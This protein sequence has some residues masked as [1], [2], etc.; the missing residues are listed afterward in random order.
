M[1][2]FLLSLAAHLVFVFTW[3]GA[4]KRE[5]P[6]DPIPVAFL[7]SP[8]PNDARPIP[9]TERPRT[10]V[11]KT[12]AQLAKKSSPLLEETAKEPFKLLETEK[13]EE[14]RAYERIERRER[15]EIVRR[16]LPTWK[17]ILPPV[18]WSQQDAE[19]RNE[20]GAVPLN[21]RQPKYLSYF[22]SIQRAIEVVWDYPEPALRHGLQG[23]LVLEF[24]I[25]RNGALGETRL[26]RSSG[27]SILDEEAIRAVQTASPFHPIPPW[28]GTDRLEISA[29]FEY[30]DNRL[31]YGFMP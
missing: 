26:V 27:F 24:T 25:L 15:Q 30:H 7:P 1:P 28:I 9:K 23:R 14:R 13:R 8:K 12:P 19:T 4:P 3:P 17:D 21:T 6:E 11:S 29:S 22:A 20:N 31:K 2:F 5:K 18:T 16:P 10:R